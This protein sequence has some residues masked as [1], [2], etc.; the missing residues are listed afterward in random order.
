LEC[1]SQIL[2]PLFKSSTIVHKQSTVS[3]NKWTSKNNSSIKT[4]SSCSDYVS[5]CE[6]FY[7]SVHEVNFVHGKKR[8][9]TIISFARNSLNSTRINAVHIQLTNQHR[10]S[11]C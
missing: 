8:Y 7:L 3:T 2:L 9:L 6:C 5:L 11:S 4:F 1:S 10:I